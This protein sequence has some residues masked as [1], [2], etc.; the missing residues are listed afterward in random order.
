MIIID[1][2]DEY[3]GLLI[4]K[5]VSNPTE[6]RYI[7]V[8]TDSL[9]L[10]IIRVLGQELTT[11]P[12]GLIDL[13]FHQMKLPRQLKSNQEIQEYIRQGLVNVLARARIALPAQNLASWI[14]KE[15]ETQTP[16]QA[17]PDV[18]TVLSDLE[19]TWVE[20]FLGQPLITAELVNQ[21]MARSI[22]IL[23][24]IRRRLQGT[25]VDTA[26]GVIDRTVRSLNRFRNS[27][28]PKYLRMG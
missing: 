9:P 2:N 12:E 11:Y 5:F 21:A 13:L 18:R 20:P 27:L 22:S 4:D 24:Q 26:T 14:H 10:P 17:G 3:L 15:M 28:L 6:I 16:T 8:G 25:K 23:E 7:H 19:E 1:P